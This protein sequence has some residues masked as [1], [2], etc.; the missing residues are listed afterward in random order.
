[1]CI[2]ISGKLYVIRTLIVINHIETEL[3]G[4]GHQTLQARQDASLL[5][6]GVKASWGSMSME[7]SL[8]TARRDT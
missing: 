1:V 5:S 2:G 7:P 3:A 8:S 4:S 6:F